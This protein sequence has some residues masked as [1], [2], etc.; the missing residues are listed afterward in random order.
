MDIKEKNGRRIAE[1]LER[2][3]PDD[4]IIRTDND[5]DLRIY[6]SGSES[7]TLTIEMCSTLDFQGDILFDPLMRIDLSLNG[8]GKVVKANPVYYTS[9][10]LFYTEEIYAEGNPDCWDPVLYKKAGELD[11]RLSEWLD[12]IQIQGYLTKGEIIKV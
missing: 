3:G 7:K 4:V 2:T 8:E 9:R 10:T 11:R 6:H 12:N 5:W 1:I